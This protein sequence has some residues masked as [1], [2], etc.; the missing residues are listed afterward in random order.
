MFTR[1]TLA[2]FAALIVGT[3]SVA[4]AMTHGKTNASQSVTKFRSTAQAGAD[5][6]WE[7]ACFDRASGG[8]NG[9]LPIV[10]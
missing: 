6:T 9:Q 1:I 10:Y 3:I 8:I 2:L 4:L 5:K 7:K